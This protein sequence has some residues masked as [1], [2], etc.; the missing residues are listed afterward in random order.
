MAPY[1]RNMPHVATYWS[2][3]LNDGFG[4]LDFSGVVPVLINC[5]WQDK[6]ELFRDANGQEQ[7][8]QAVVYPDRELAVR[9]YLALGDKTEMGMAGDPRTIPTAREVRHV[10]ASPSLANDETLYRVLL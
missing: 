4:N 2:P 7:I 6:Q 9:G 3:G 5:R 10:G 1:T 8:S